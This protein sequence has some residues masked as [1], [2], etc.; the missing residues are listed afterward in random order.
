ARVLRATVSR[1]GGRWFVSFTCE[2]ERE[3]GTPRRPGAGV[4]VDVGVRHLAV[5]STGETVPHPRP[6]RKALRKLARL[7]RELA[8]R[9]RGSRG[10]EETRRRLARLHARIAHIR[11]DALHKLTARLAHTYGTVVVERLHVAGMLRHRRL[12]RAVA[13]AGMAEIRRQLA[14]KTAWSGSRLV[15]ADPFFPS[16]KR[17]SGC[18]AVKDTLPLWERTFRCGACGLVRDRD[19]NA[20]QNLAA[21]AAAVAGSGP[22]TENARGRGVRPA[23]RRAAPDEAG[24]RRRGSA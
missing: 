19:E 24:S 3:P 18:G 22:E 7:N 11:R 14:Y 4:G 21:L 10:W 23:D 16:S 17:C 6:L 13:D 8:R 20:A 2:V 9:R 12:A 1:E 15:E 5:L